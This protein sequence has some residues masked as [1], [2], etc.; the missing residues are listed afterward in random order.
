M[1]F[2]LGTAARNDF[3]A[4]SISRT[5]SV[6]VSEWCTAILAATMSSSG[7]ACSIRKWMLFVSEFPGALITDQQPYLVTGISNT[8]ESF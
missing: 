8:L 3:S 7:P 6:P 2:A 4:L 1:Y 5:I